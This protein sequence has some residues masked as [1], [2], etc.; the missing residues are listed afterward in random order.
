MKLYILLY[1][2]YGNS[3]REQ[4][5]D[6][7]QCKAAYKRLWVADGVEGLEAFASIILDKP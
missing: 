5:H 2:Q 7:N 1:R 6:L 3:M 4:F